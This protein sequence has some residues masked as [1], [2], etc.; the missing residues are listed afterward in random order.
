MMPCKPFPLLRLSYIF[1]LQKSWLSIGIPLFQ[2][3]YGI[4]FLV[5]ELCKW[6]WELNLFY[7]NLGSVNRNKCIYVINKCIVHIKLNVYILKHKK[8]TSSSW[9]H[10]DTPW[11]DCFSTWGSTFCICKYMRLCTCSV[12]LLFSLIL[13]VN[14]SNSPIYWPEHN[15]YISN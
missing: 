8:A 11:P 6:S 12:D 7:C 10:G 15:Q 4:Y 1:M 2:I 3:F 9:Y 13:S 5:S 14:F